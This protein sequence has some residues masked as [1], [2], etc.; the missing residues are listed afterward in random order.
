MARV[1]IALVIATAILALAPPR[2][3]AASVAGR[4][5]WTVRHLYFTI[6]TFSC[7]EGE[8]SGVTALDP[9]CNFQVRWGASGTT[10]TYN[11]VVSDIIINTNAPRWNYQRTG[12]ATGWDGSVYF[13]VSCWESDAAGQLNG[14]YMGVVTKN[15]PSMQ[16]NY[17]Y[18]TITSATSW[19]G[20]SIGA[21]GGGCATV[22][23]VYVYYRA[24]CDA[25]YYGPTCNEFCQ[26]GSPA[27]CTACNSVTGACTCSAGYLGKDC[28][29]CDAA[30]QYYSNGAGI[31]T[32]CIPENSATAGYNCLTDGTRSCLPGWKGSNC[33]IR[34]SCLP[35]PPAPA[36]A[37]ANSCTTTYGST[38]TYSCQSGYAATSGST[39]ST[40][41]TDQ[42]LWSSFSLT[43]N[44]IDECAPG[45]GNLCAQ[46]CSDTIGNYTCSCRSGYHQNGNG[47]GVG[48]C[49]S[50]NECAANNG[51]C[52]QNCIDTPE[53][54]YCGCFS[55]YRLAGDGTSCP[56]IDECAE[57]LDNC[58]A[59]ATCTNA[60]GSFLCNC[61]SGY[62]GNGV[63]CTDIDECAAPAAPCDPNAGCLN[64][65]GTF[66]CTCDVGFVGNGFSCVANNSAS[67][68][69]DLRLVVTSEGTTVL[70][71]VNTTVAR[72]GSLVYFTVTG[73]E[74]VLGEDYVVVTPSP[75][76][77]NLGDTVKAIEIT[78]IADGVAEDVEKLTVQLYDARYLSIGEHN[79]STVVID[80]NDHTNGA[81]RM[82]PES[83]D[84]RVSI[85]AGSYPLTVERYAA[86]S[87]DQA[88]NVTIHRG[89]GVARRDALADQDFTLIIPANSNQATLNVPLP[90][91]TTPSLDVTY[92][93]SLAEA[94]MVGGG[95]APALGY[96][97]SASVTVD[98]HDDPYGV[99][100][101]AFA[102]ARLNESST[103]QILVTRSQGMFGTT[104]VRVRTTVLTV[105]QA[106]GVQLAS[107]SD[108]TPFSTLL[109]FTPSDSS[110][111]VPITIVADGIPEVDEIFGVVLELVSGNGRIDPSAALEKITIPENDDARGV[112][113]VTRISSCSEESLVVGGVLQPNNTVQVEI[114]RSAG[115]YGD[116]S[117]SWSTHDGKFDDATLLS[118]NTALAAQPDYN[119]VTRQV[120]TMGAGVD[121][122]QISVQ[123]LDD[124]V[125]ELDEYFY[126]QLDGAMGGARIDPINNFTDVCISNNDVP[127]GQLAFEHPSDMRLGPAG[128]RRWLF[129]QGDTM[130][131]VVKRYY[132]A[133]HAISG[134]VTIV[135]GSDASP[136]EASDFVGGVVTQPVSFA[137]G[138][139]SK[140]LY[141][142]A[143]NDS[144]A[145]ADY[146]TFRFVL[147][148]NGASSGEE[149]TSLLTTSSLDSQ[150]PAVIDAK[151]PGQGV[152]GFV[153]TDIS[154]QEVT[155]L[156]TLFVTRNGASQS[157]VTYTT[158]ARAGTASV[159]DFDASN[160]NN[161]HTLAQSDSTQGFSLAIL[162]DD[163]PEGSETFTVELQNVVGARRA[164]ACV[165]TVTIVASDDG[166]GVIAFANS[167]TTDTPVIASVSENS[168]TL[169]LPLLR[170]IGLFGQVTVTFVISTDVRS[171]A[172]LDPLRQLSLP[173]ARSNLTRDIDEMPYEVVFA[174][175][176]DEG[177]LDI[178]IYD[179]AG[180]QGTR[181]FFIRL[182]LVAG[183]A[184]LGAQRAM[185]VLITDNERAPPPS[186]NGSTSAA[187]V[188][189]AVGVPAVLLLI[190]LLIVLLLVAA[191][192]KH[193]KEKRAREPPMSLTGSV[194][195]IE[196]N[197]LRRSDNGTYDTLHPQ[198]STYDTL[199]GAG[200]D[201][202]VDN[203]IYD[204][205]VD[206]N[207]QLYDTLNG[208]GNR[209]PPPPA[210][211]PG[212]TYAQLDH[213]S[214]TNSAPPSIGSPA[215]DYEEFASAAHQ[216]KMEEAVGQM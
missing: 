118:Q 94:A 25:G 65:P 43:C 21:L 141:W 73:V 81:V 89:S 51:G 130:A 144:I 158:Y 178:P 68:M 3:Q 19:T 11:A 208:A 159:D 160:T 117:F 167:T 28:N 82:V 152:L 146:K 155:E 179:T 183:G 147:S 186:D 6:S 37:V 180:Y 126:V 201:S 74:A 197:P 60:P 8:S 212:S 148:A 13:S 30:N 40:T 101:L 88:V 187:T 95:P 9:Y 34:K 114:R 90:L 10:N 136:A 57:N 176:Q 166:N 199:G 121:R 47:R 213:Q 181:V 1:L 56:D 210:T 150:I 61:I 172:D 168:G 122:I 134:L 35:N 151:A 138:E 140:V 17:A 75:L 149:A 128:V 63:T 93:Y 14:N 112:L 133:F 198:D 62:S 55:G 193:K 22:P 214:P 154:V 215:A 64:L 119:A 76:E 33:N 177:F 165:A 4:I 20:M 87:L 204:V 192:R 12:T 171:H 53:S 39:S 142:T 50:I 109:T 79:Q 191:R 105:N 54:F 123:L 113:S 92:T 36:N 16:T 111:T 31:C 170:E 203:P 44:N 15:I 106:G 169:R 72:D 129:Q 211:V 194:V 115:L 205:S 175:G 38:C 100:G 27:A 184:R 120:V 216:R 80:A 145:D 96:Y 162:D 102:T 42:E 200:Y 135:M 209:P 127:Y 77:F 5:S 143:A 18:G 41:C 70:L 107:A 52:S 202:R 84:L 132:G 188:G 23:N 24:D 69:A 67:F 196:L 110:L 46:I 104:V 182:T 207:N 85:T 185:A 153:A 190:I 7:D 98:A 124:A 48:G 59:N 164:W 195:G 99:F 206:D 137:E 29:T 108:F 125:P 2:A 163:I 86:A 66:K 161:A 157:A 156:V 58:H 139:T 97:A 131:V 91:S 26:V 49:T 32:Q 45:G 173:P 83:R 71:Y 116:I 174:D 78:I 189:I 103:T